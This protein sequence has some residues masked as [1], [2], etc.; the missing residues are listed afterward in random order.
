MSKPL[1]HPVSVPAS[2]TLNVSRKGETRPEAGQDPGPEPGPVAAGAQ[3]RHR[4]LGRCRCC[5]SEPYKSQL[6]A[7]DGED[8]AR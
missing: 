2:S 7:V 3:R 5:R 1:I 4:Q 8:R 6:A